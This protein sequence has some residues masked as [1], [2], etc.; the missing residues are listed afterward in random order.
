[1]KTKVKSRERRLYSAEEYG[2]KYW[3]DHWAEF[4]HNSVRYVNKCY[5]MSK[6]YRKTPLP[7]IGKQ[8]GIKKQR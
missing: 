6:K 1:M 3:R 4:S 7:V 8:G 5:Q 2:R